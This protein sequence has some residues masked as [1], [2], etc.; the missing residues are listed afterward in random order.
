M[1]KGAGAKAAHSAAPEVVAPPVAPLVASA[2]A[3]GF[4]SIPIAQIAASPYQPRRNFDEAKIAEMAD[5]IAAHG[6]VEPIVVWRVDAAHYYVIAGERRLRALT[7]L[8]WDTAPAVLSDAAES[9]LRE[10]ALVENLQ[11]EDLNAIETA[12]ALHELNATLTHE[13]IAKRIGKSRAWITNLIRLLDL[14]KEVRDFIVAK[15]ISPAHGRTLLGLSD[16]L[17][18]IKL[19]QK[20]IAESIPV[21]ALE[22]IINR[23]SG[24]GRGPQKKSSAT[25]NADPAQARQL[26]DWEKQLSARFGAQTKILDR[27]GA[28]VIEIRY[29]SRDEFAGIVER[30]NL[31]PD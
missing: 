27:G 6:L 2:P 14:P 3:N 19:A 12:E 21:Q 17:S 25:P 28:G 15:K 9:D 8:G 13:K 1:I 24:A 29:G 20:I 4:L 30:L 18:Q 26:G 16:P 22:K 10:I 31:A 23:M 7:Q 5:S 11:R